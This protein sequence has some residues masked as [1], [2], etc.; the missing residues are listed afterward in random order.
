[1]TPEQRKGAH[2]T[3]ETVVRNGVLMNKD[4]VDGAGGKATSKR[5]DEPT[6]ADLD[7]ALADVL[8]LIKTGAV[9]DVDVTIS[10]LRSH[11]GDVLFNA[12]AEKTVRTAF[13]DRAKNLK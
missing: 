12:A 10:D 8:T 2:G 4:D 6:K 9:K 1:M 3:C 13:E 11:F 7:T 5:I